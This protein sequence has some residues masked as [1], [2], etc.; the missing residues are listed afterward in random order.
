MPDMNLVID[1]QAMAHILRSPA[2]PVARHLIERATLVQAKAKEIVHSHR[3]TGCL[4]DSIVKRVETNGVELAIRI[5]SDT[6]P[7]SPTRTSYSLM[8]HDGTTAH[9]IIATNAQALRF[10]IGGEVIFAQR[11]HHPGTAGVPFLRD[12]LK[13][14][15]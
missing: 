6:T 11:V 14:L 13:V 12:A 2:G 5:V 10:E 15:H 4:E 9:D 7:C 8:F 1:G 3:K